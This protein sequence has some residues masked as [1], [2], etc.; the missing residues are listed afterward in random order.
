MVLFHLQLAVDAADNIRAIKVP[1]T[2]VYCF[3]FKHSRGEDVRQKVTVSRLSEQEVPNSRGKCNLVLHFEKQAATLKIEDQKK[4]TKPEI[5]LNQDGLDQYVTVCSMECRGL[6]PVTFYPGDDFIIIA[7]SGHT[8]N[9]CDLSDPD[10][11][12][13]YDPDGQVPVSVGKLSYR[14]TAKP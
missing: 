13:E 12:C 4:V 10:G 14:I 6:E 3:D 5:D 7:E 11:W 2:Y 9:K 1:E 8:F